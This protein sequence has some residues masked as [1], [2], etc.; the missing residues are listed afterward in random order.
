[1]QFVM[2]AATILYTWATLVSFYIIIRRNDLNE[3]I[4]M[5]SRDFRPELW[6]ELREAPLK[7]HLEIVEMKIWQIFII[8]LLPN[9][10]TMAYILYRGDLLMGS[11][12]VTGSLE[13][14]PRLVIFMQ[15]FGYWCWLFR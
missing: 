14:A 6:P 15:F 7:K 3:L 5:W 1:M 12:F 10:V 9:G 4:S 8:C 2:I 11:M 13:G